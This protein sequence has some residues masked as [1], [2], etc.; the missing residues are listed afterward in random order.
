MLRLCAV[1]LVQAS[2][3]CLFYGIGDSDPLREE[4]Q[5]LGDEREERVLVVFKSFCSLHLVGYRR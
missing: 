1:S 2:F 3:F 5:K 4:K